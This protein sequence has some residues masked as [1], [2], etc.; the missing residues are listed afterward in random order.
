MRTKCLL[1][2]AATS[3]KWEN[4]YISYVFMGKTKAVPDT[5]VFR[6]MMMM[7]AAAVAS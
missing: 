7:I 1:C 4:I 6:M 2:A 3:P 5:D